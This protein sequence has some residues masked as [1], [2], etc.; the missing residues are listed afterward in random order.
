MRCPRSPL[1]R[2]RLLELAHLESTRARR[3]RA[4]RREDRF[5]S[6]APVSASAHRCQRDLYPALTRGHVSDR[7]PA[8]AIFVDAT[9]FDAG[10]AAEMLLT[11]ALAQRIGVKAG[12]TFEGNFETTNLQPVALAVVRF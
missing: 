6:G 10:Y 4:D 1:R 3:C 8:E 2:T 9:F 5:P 12:L 7:L 11:R